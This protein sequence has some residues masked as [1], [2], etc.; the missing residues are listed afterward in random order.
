MASLL[1]VRTISKHFGGVR[2][3]DEL[4]FAIPEGGIQAL[5]GPNGSGKTT[6]INLITGCYRLT[7]GEIHFAG[8]RIDALP[9][10]QIVQRGLARTF[11]NLRLFETLTVLD[12]VLMGQFLHARVEFLRT[13][14]QSRKAK[15]E[16][17]AALER[18]WELLELV[19]L[20]EKAYLLARNLPYGQRRLL[21]IARALATQPKLLFLD[22]PA[23]GMSEEEID[24]VIDLIRTIQKRGVTI[25]LV[26]HRMRLVMNVSQHIVVLNYG[27]KI[28][29]GSTD[30]IQDNQEVITAYLGKRHEKVG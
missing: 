5:I 6:C 8:R 21:E 14:L 18:S 13:V 2:A 23:A 7:G 26:E 3:V 29:E 9:R 16:T 20:R 27:K 19:G 15:A 1:E 17:R 28:A 24:R 30:Q 25:L 10:E 12:H 22:E 11:Q 4:S